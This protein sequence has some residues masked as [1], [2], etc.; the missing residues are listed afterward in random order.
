MIKGSK[1]KGKLKICQENGK[2][3]E[4]NNGCDSRK[5]E[6]DLKH[7]VVI[8]AGIPGYFQHHDHQLFDSRN[9]KE[10]REDFKGQFK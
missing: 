8:Q 1:N 4:Q 3:E 2:A 10:K 7:M 6:K 9:K 5:T